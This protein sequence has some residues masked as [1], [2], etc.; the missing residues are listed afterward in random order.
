MEY[1]YH[2]INA[3]ENRFRFYSMMIEKTLFGE[4]ILSCTWGRIGTGGQGKMF[5]YDSLAECM[6]KLK[7]IVKVRGSH[8]YCAG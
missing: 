8:G 2:S 7:C 3:A 4:F 6:E 1:N 5:F